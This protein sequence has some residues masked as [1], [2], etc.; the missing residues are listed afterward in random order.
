MSDSL[1]PQGLQHAKFLCP[2]PTPRV[3]SNG[4]PSSCWCL[5][6]ISSSVI[7]FSSCLQ[8]CPASGSFPMSQFSHQVAK[9]LELQHQSFQWISRTE[10]LQD[11]LVSSPCSPRDSQES[12]PKPKFK[13]MDSSAFSFLYSPTLTWLLGK[14]EP[15]LDRPLLAK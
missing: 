12:S 7:P 1:Q 5:S 4:C 6:T 2:L 15:W 13:S 8:S 14:P 9:V 10:F 3:C 11:W